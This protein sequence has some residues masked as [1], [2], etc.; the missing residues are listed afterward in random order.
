MANIFGITGLRVAVIDAKLS[1]TDGRNLDEVNSFMAEHDGNIV[2]IKT[3]QMMYGVTRFIIT[4][5]EEA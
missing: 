3:A 4:Y 5:R 1:D 2:E